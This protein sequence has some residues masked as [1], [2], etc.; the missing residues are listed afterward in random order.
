MD[1]NS[2]NKEVA[3]PDQPAEK[4]NESEG[5]FAKLR[6]AKEKAELVAEHE[7]NE[8]LRLQQEI[9]S[10]RAQKL[11]PKSDEEE[12]EDDGYVDARALK[13]TIKRLESDFDRKVEEKLVKKLD[14][15]NRKNFMFKLK[16]EYP[17]FDHVLTE[18]TAA[19]LEQAN[20]KLAQMILNVPDEYQRRA[21]AYEAIKTAGLHKKAEPAAKE[22]VQDKI[23]QNQRSLYYIP[24]ATGTAGM[25]S[26]DF[27][28]EGRKAAYAR[29][30]NLKS[31]VAAR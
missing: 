11:S 25:P 27:S 1:V 26:G 8:R 16:S 7:R 24:P 21:M 17:D 23:N 18:E 15:E 19:K 31:A 2:V 4:K 22:S 12:E 30:K 10:I 6:Q 13:R 29:L 14:E 5:H 20:P 28:P 9:D 3:T